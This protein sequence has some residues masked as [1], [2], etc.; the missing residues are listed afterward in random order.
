MRPLF[1]KLV[2]FAIVFALATGPAQAALWSLNYDGL[3][4]AGSTSTDGTAIRNGTAFSV[5]AIFSDTTGFSTGGVVLYQ[6]SAINLTL[7]GH[8]LPVDAGRISNYIDRYIVI[9]TPLSS[10]VGAY[11][12]ALE[13]IGAGGYGGGFI[14]FYGTATPALDITHPFA[15]TFSSY[16]KS[17]N[18]RLPITIVG[19]GFLTLAYDPGVGLK[20]SITAVPEPEEWAMMLVGSGLISWQLRR[21]AK[22]AA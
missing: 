15:T 5:H 21:R 18:N 7:S 20:T 22:V 10:S 1:G 19:G 11:G 16:G 9:L 3:T 14:P 13:Y 2:A 6:T 12:A 4:A 8:T 17:F